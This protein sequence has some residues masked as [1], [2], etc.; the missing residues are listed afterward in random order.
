MY[1]IV[2]Y[3]EGIV[4]SLQNAV[5]SSVSSAITSIADSIDRSVVRPLSET[6]ST[7]IGSLENVLNYV[8]RGVQSGVSQTVTNLSTTLNQV[9][10]NVQTSLTSTVRS[11][12]STFSSIVDTLST[13]L[14]KFVASL[15]RGFTDVQSGFAHAIE[16]AVT[17]LEDSFTAVGKSLEQTVS[18]LLTPFLHFIEGIPKDIETIAEAAG[19]AIGNLAKEAKQIAENTGAQLE[20]GIMTAEATIK[21][22]SDP[23][24]WE[25]PRQLFG[26]TIF[27][28]IGLITGIDLSKADP[29][30]ISRL[31]A[32]FAAEFAASSAVP[33][34]EGL[35]FMMGNQL[36]ALL[37]VALQG[38]WRDLEQ[39]ANAGV[40]NKLPPVGELIAARY[41]GYVDDAYFYDRM[42]R[43]GFS[44]TSADLIYRT[45]DT[46]LSLGELVALYRRGKLGDIN[47]LY[48]QAAKV[49]AD[50]YQVNNALLLY[51]TLMSAGEQIELWRRDI[52]PKGWSDS[53]DDARASG[54]TETRL[55]AIKEAS[56]K[57]PSIYDEQEF[58]RR[59]VYD[60]QWVEKYGL[61]YGLDE[62][63]YKV[64]KANG[65]DRET[66]KKLY[67]RYWSVPPFFITEGLYRTGKLDRDTF[68]RLLIMEGYTPEWSDEFIKQL[69]PNLTLSDIKEEYKYQVITADQIVPEIVSIGYTEDLARK[70]RDLWVASIKLAG[71]LESTA[72]Q[73]QAQTIKGETESLIKTGYK[74]HVLSRDKA[75]SAL[76]TIGYTEQA[77]GLVLD[78]ADYDMQQQHISD[79]YSIVET[80][81]LSGQIDENTAIQALVQAGASHEQVIKYQAKLDR[82]G[83]T[84]PKVPTLAEFGG[85]F[86]KNIISVEQLAAGISLLGYSDTWV[87]FFLLQYGATMSDLKSL[88]YSLSVPSV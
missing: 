81:Y 58:I 16:R 25:G 45:G 76:E 33:F 55:D 40:P 11:V 34:D 9:E 42:E 84:K 15:E 69:Q 87:P 83:R 52:V 2:S 8:V 20:G 75:Q 64:A 61:D 57:L 59:N 80:Q 67:R 54:I 14:E 72:N 7:G 79:T 26:N 24:T 37:Q 17:S 5:R 1:D 4:G 12:E 46:L 74:D 88:G 71:P 41:K 48:T 85:W 62:N 47:E 78:I 10:S 36:P 65:Y 39:M 29:I 60:E 51:D 21:N 18:S 68:K 73:Q 22:I 66:A 19:K 50:Q 32:G 38:S 86:K 23:T 49:R 3:I 31:G 35:A 28:I 56:Y 63:Y 13:D 27:D 82:A 77:A 70:Y 43:H 53:F 44:D 6:I 30:A